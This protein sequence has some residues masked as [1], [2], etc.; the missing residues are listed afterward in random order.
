MSMFKKTNPQQSLFGI[1]TQLSEGLQTRL[2]S[3]WAHLFKVEILPILFRSEENFSMLYGKTGRPNFSVAR[4]IGLCLL[5]EYNALSDQ[6][7]LDAFGF[8]IRWRYALDVSDDQA[9]L[10]RR[11]LVEFRRRLAAKDPEMKLVRG[12]FE[13]I[14]KR[15]I[16]KLDLSASQQR[17]DSTLVVSNI[18]TR[19]RLDLF[20]NTIT[21]FI[22]SLDKKRFSQIPDHIRQW[23]KREPEGWFGLAQDQH[24]AKLEQ[25][26]QYVYKLIQV[27]ETDK[28]VKDSEQYELL[29]R[30]FQE[31]CEIKKD[32]NS[33]TSKGDDKKIKIKKKTQGETLQ[34]AFDPDASYG[35]K[36]S[37]YS[38]HIT[39]TC[40][41]KNKKEI[42]TDY[43]VHGAARSDMGKAPDILNRL[44]SAGLKPEKLFADGGYPSVPS[45]LKVKKREVEFIAP[46]N[47]SRIPDEVMGRDQ[48]E[49]NKDG[50]AV[51]CPKGHI[52]I[53]HRML[54]HNNKKGKSLHAIFDGDIC[55][56][57]I[58]LDN[59][60]VRAPN[61]RA[62]GCK[63]R[64]TVGNFR[65]EITPELRL[66]DQMYSNQQTTE[67]KEQYKIR[68]GVEATMSELKRK[69]G[70]GKLRVRRAAKV[71]FAVACKVIACNI[72]RWA[73]A[74]AVSEKALLRIIS[75]ILDRLNAFETDPDQ[76]ISLLVNKS[77]LA[78]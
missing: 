17:L 41:N 21:L 65:L 15:A 55:R 23:H 78:A 14:S 71:C 67:W 8:D 13:K 73:K 11:S 32:S 66:R 77:I 61:H 51:K 22:R 72:K 26:S 18:R 24:K 38:A 3:S 58:I 76:N 29:V 34:S 33:D 69:H 30:L 9:Y 63:P 5:Q 43:E 50:L 49:F 36:G 52:P 46:V 16:K 4:A 45:A 60:P 20:A 35:H 56:K 31:Q 75:L 25:L 54:S 6:Q 44:E 27:F 28:E 10:S 48:F 39:E 2:R 62:R 47:R 37:G 68:S 19:G 12:I 57:C 53:D 64:D 59:C 1:D 70:M 40:N 42:I 74:L 7:A